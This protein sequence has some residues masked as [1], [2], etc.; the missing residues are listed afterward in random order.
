MGCNI[1]EE[2]EGGQGEGDV[3]T[4]NWDMGLM[5]IWIDPPFCK[6][7]IA[8]LHSQFKGGGG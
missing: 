2:S 8:R 3:T 7:P 4:R 6:V 5:K 1:S